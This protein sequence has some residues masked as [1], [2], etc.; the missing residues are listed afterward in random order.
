MSSPQTSRRA[1]SLVFSSVSALSSATSSYAVRPRSS[2][3]MMTRG[4]PLSMQVTSRVPTPETVTESRTWPV[5]SRLE[6]TEPA[7]SRKSMVMGAAEPGTP[8]MLADPAYSTARRPS[9]FGVWT[10]MSHSMSVLSVSTRAVVVS[11]W[12]GS[13]PVSSANGTTAASMLPQLGVVSTVSWSGCSWAKRNSR[14]TSSRSLR[15]TMPTLLV[16]GCAPPSPSIWR[17]SGEPITASR[18]RSRVGRSSGRS[19]ASKNGPRDVPPRMN[20]HGTARCVTE[21]ESSPGP[22]GGAK[23]HPDPGRPRRRLW[24]A[25]PD[26]SPDLRGW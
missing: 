4:M 3:R 24:C 25:P 8:S 26:S 6:Q 11:P 2:A 12:A 13:K 16:S 14:S 21:I 7:V 15:L 18:T 1:S 23:A 22:T 5:G 17:R 9:S 10:V 20:K 19:A